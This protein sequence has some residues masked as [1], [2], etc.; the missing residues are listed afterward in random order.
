MVEGGPQINIA[1]KIN[2]RRSGAAIHI[3]LAHRLPSTAE[4]EGTFLRGRTQPQC[5]GAGRCLAG[6]AR[7]HCRRRAQQTDTG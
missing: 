4:H 2:V 5:A 6:P 3:E 1:Q 7:E